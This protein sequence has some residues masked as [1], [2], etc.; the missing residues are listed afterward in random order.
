MFTPYT[1]VI[2]TVEQLSQI[3]LL[4]ADMWQQQLHSTWRTGLPEREASAR[5]A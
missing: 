4:N 3:C 1:G 2:A 5:L